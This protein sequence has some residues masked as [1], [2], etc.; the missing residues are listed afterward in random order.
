METVSDPTPVRRPRHLMD[1]DNPVRPVNDHS[2]TQVQRWVLSVLAVT[3]ILHLSAGLVIGAFFL[4]EAQAGLAVRAVRHRRP[5]RR[6]GRGGGPADPPEADGVVVAGGGLPAGA[7]RH[8]AGAEGLTAP[9]AVGD[10]RVAGGL[11]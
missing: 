6:G 4:D 11:G 1:P 8:R 5:V 10:Q 2:L 3:T 7:G 9:A